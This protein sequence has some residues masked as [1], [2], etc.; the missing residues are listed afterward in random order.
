MSCIWDY[1]A[2][3]RICINI[4]YQDIWCPFPAQCYENGLYPN[5]LRENKIVFKVV[6]RHNHALISLNWHVTWPR[7]LSLPCF[8]CN[9]WGHR[10]QVTCVVCFWLRS[11]LNIIVYSELSP[12]SHK[13]GYVPIYF[14]YLSHTAITLGCT[15]INGLQPRCFCWFTKQKAI[16]TGKPQ[17]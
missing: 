10:N 3:F 14:F 12:R 7:I 4:E 11:I 8:F 6:C 16:D 1:S 15:C 13:L 17:W 9:R 5:I 2:I